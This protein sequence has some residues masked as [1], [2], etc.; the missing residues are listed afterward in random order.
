M[1]FECLALAPVRFFERND[2]FAMNFSMEGRYPLA[3]KKFMDYAFSMPSKIKNVGALP[4]VIPRQY[5]SKKSFPHNYGGPVYRP[6][7]RVRI[8]KC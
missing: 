2:K 6:I 1:L 8:A 7:W 5:F 3:S 4:R